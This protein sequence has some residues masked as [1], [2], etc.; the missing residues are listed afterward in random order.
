MAKSQIE[1]ILNILFWW[2]QKTFGPFHRALWKSE[3][4]YWK[5]KKTRHMWLLFD[6]LVGTYSK[7]GAGIAQSV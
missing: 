1:N 2:S 6:Y 3:L 7:I 5:K 4:L